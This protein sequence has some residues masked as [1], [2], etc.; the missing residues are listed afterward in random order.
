VLDPVDVEA[1]AFVTCGVAIVT[2]AVTAMVA[3]AVVIAVTAVVTV[4]VVVVVVMGT[5]A[6]MEAM[7]L[8]RNS[9]SLASS[10]ISLK[11]R[12]VIFSLDRVLDLESIGVDI[13][14]FECFPIPGCLPLFA[15]MDT[16]LNKVH[17]VRTSGGD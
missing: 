12:P 7:A 5:V 1:P 9:L 2:A 15:G 17:R 3:A 16:A 6:G 13:G 4:V 8:A 11:N 10:S 14:R